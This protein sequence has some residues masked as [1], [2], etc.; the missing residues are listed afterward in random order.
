MT[1]TRINL[2]RKRVPYILVENKEWDRKNGFW[3]GPERIKFDIASPC[4]FETTRQFWGNGYGWIHYN[5]R[6]QMGRNEDESAKVCIEYRR[7]DNQ[8]LFDAHGLSEGDMEWGHH[9]LIIEDGANC[10]PSVWNGNEGPGWKLETINGGKRDRK[11]STVHAIQRGEQGVFRQHLLAMDGCCALTGET[12]EAALEAA[13]VFP[14]HRGGREVLS[15]GILLRSD[16]H[17][18]YDYS[19]PKFEICPGTG[20]VLTDEEFH[21]ES[22]DLQGVR[23]DAALLERIS[24]ALELRNRD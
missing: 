19:P 9:L 17:R 22:F 20:M 10:G 2:G 5:V 16:I 23:I 21:Y 18:L 14:A 11:R 7:E 4:E 3:G 13:H 15:N 6:V 12:C 1:R 24:E 8:H